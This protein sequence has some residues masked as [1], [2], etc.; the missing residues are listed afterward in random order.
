MKEKFKICP[1][2]SEPF[3]LFNSLQPCCPKIECIKKHNSKKE[4]NK[5]VKEMKKDVQSL[6]DCRAI[7]RAAFQTWIRL[8][9]QFKGCV[10]CGKR[11]GKF[12]GGHYLSAERYTGL[13][14]D[15]DNCHKQCSRPCNKDLGGNTHEYRKGL[16][17]RIGLQ[18]VEEL[19]ARADLS[20][21]YKFTK[22]ELLDIATEYKKRI[23]DLK[24]IKAA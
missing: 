18:R 3:K 10:S 7:A 13:I 20:R 19:E 5:R 21:T 4:V 11:D 8:R 1:Y 23:K 16:I 14:F 24:M 17:L 12:D 15:E 2:C 22:Q 6:N 9:D